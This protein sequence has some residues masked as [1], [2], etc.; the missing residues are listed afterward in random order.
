[1]GPFDEAEW[2]QFFK[3]AVLHER[4]DQDT[5]EHEKESIEAST[6][7]ALHQNYNAL[8]TQVAAEAVKYCKTTFA[9]YVKK[10][11]KYKQ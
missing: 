9:Y 11:E 2:S 3:N 7:G 5:D 6:D 10:M 4:G 8:L 1:M